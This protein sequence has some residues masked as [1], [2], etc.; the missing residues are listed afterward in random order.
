MMDMIVDGMAQF[1]HTASDPGVAALHVGSATPATSLDVPAVV[2]SLLIDN[3]SGNGLGSFLR[4]GHQLTQN[5]AVIAVQPDPSTFSADLK[6]LQ[7]PLPLRNPDDVQVG[8]VTGP[9]QVAPYKLA[10]RPA[11]ADEF[12]VDPLRGL[13]IFGAPQTQG[14]Q[15]R[16]VSWTTL[17]RDDI[18]G[19]RCNGTMSLEVWTAS[20][21]DLSGLSSQIQ[22]KI[23]NDRAGLRQAGFGVFQPAALGAGENADY[24]PATGNVF[25]V[26][27]QALSYKFHF[28]AEQAGGASSGG[29]IKQINVQLP[30]ESESLA[31]PASS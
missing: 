30:A 16:V 12:R 23:F 29:P 21:A 25:R 19:A 15:L 22:A 7:L 10:A 4:E 6:T 8:L 26:W 13:V 27:K 28:D 18:R 9:N 11:T 14:Q 3:T 17:F 2:V 31:I 24:Q 20:A 1:L 5:T